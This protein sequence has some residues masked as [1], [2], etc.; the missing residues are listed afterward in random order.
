MVA[1]GFLKA[2]VF[3]ALVA[4][5]QG[6]RRRAQTGGHAECFVCGDA[7]ATVQNIDGE[8]PA[9]PGFIV[10]PGTVS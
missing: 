3:C 1:G 9:P 5:G 7:G 4:Y 2:V 6:Q 10:P 8:A